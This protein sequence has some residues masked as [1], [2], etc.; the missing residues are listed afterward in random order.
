LSSLGF[1]LKSNELFLFNKTSEKQKMIQKISG[2]KL[3][4]QGPIKMFYPGF[5]LGKT[6]TGFASIARI[7]HAF[8]K[9]DNIIRM[10]PHINDEILTYLRS[11]N[12]EHLDS[13]GFKK[14]INSTTLMLMKA[15][16]S[17]YHEEKI[18]DNGEALE[19]LQI[20]IRPKQKD[21]N[22]LVTF[23][24]LDDAF[25]NNKWRLIASPS[26]KTTLQFTSDTW[27]YDM[28]VSNNKTFQLPLLEKEN[29]TCLLYVFNGNLSVNNSIELTKKDSLLLKNENITIQTNEET[30]LVLFVTDEAAECYDGGMFSGN[31]M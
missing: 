8:F 30:D 23:L 21:L 6:D 18:I 27:I 31:Q 15:G 24:E 5:A 11:G 4:G 2:D 3:I 10:H 14:N 9:G 1:I 26:E 25:S 29:L 16:S 28:K 7:D 22:P 13:E 17:F 19:G 12:A 20:F